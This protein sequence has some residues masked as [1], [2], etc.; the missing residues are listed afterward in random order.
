[1]AWSKQ[2]TT[3]VQKATC[4]EGQLGK[5]R[6]WLATCL[7]P[8]G[9]CVSSHQIGKMHKRPRSLSVDAGPGV[10]PS[11]SYSHM[12]PRSIAVDAGSGVL[13][14]QS[15]SH[16]GPRSIPVAAGPGVTSQS[17]PH[18]GPRALRKG[19]NTASAKHRPLYPKTHTYMSNAYNVA[20]CVDVGPG[21]LK[22]RGT[23]HGEPR[24]DFGGAGRPFPLDSRGVLH[25][26]GA[27]GLLPHF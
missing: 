18:K 24:S 14:S 11:Q 23:G 10:L 5:I 9:R 17:Y 2:R 12:G 1:M 3:H 13:P 16:K 27:V 19:R 6:Q 15:Y 20:M 8:G 22:K 4:N 26:C 7:L 21:V 25:S